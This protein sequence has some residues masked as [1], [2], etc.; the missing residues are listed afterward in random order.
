MMLSNC[1]FEIFV[2]SLKPYPANQP[3]LVKKMMIRGRLDGFLS[4][5][6]IIPRID[7]I[8]LFP[9]SFGV[10]MWYNE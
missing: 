1:S 3:L 10:A 5:Y 4:Y 2:G 6:H 7:S 8:C 9:V